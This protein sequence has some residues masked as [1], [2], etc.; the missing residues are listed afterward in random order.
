MSIGLTTEPK[1][2]YPV[3]I[4]F[5][6][7]S[8]PIILCIQFLLNLNV[9]QEKFQVNFQYMDSAQPTQTQ[10]FGTLLTRSFQTFSDTQANS[11]NIF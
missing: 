10:M 3:L 6:F 1:M 11:V 4:F 2:F 7:Y 5:R 9:I 8:R